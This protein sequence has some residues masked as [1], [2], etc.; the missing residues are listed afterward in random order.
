MFYYIGFSCY[1]AFAEGAVFRF[2][3]RSSVVL[4]QLSVDL[5]EMLHGRG[6]DTIGS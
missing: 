5:G 4:S 6:L 2:L 3:N 1:N